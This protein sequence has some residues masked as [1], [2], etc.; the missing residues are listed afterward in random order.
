MMVD[1]SQSVQ[2]NVLVVVSIVTRSMCLAVF[3]RLALTTIWITTMTNHKRKLANE[4]YRQMTANGGGTVWLSTEYSTGY[5]VALPSRELRVSDYLAK[6]SLIQYYIENLV[7]PG[8]DGIGI[9]NNTDESKVYIDSVLHVND[10]NTAVKLG[11]EFNQ[12][13]IYCLDTNEVIDL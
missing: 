8:S 10:Y 6:P 4:L 9:W 5:V 13:A 1:S 3:H 2:S 7:Q 11:R 12:L